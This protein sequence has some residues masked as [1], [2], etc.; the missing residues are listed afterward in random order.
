MIMVLLF[1]YESIS[2]IFKDL[3]DQKKKNEHIMGS[4]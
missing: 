3:T 1:I 2:T 4:L